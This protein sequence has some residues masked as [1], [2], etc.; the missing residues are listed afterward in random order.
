MAGACTPRVDEHLQ[1]ITP[2]LAEMARE[3]AIM[4]AELWQRQ[5]RLR[6]YVADAQMVRPKPERTQRPDP[7]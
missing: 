2:H 3:V 6:R 1:H 7:Q 5:R 4:R